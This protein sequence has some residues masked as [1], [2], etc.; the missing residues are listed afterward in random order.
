MAG[1][2]AMAQGAPDPFFD[3][4]SPELDANGDHVPDD[5][6]IRRREIWSE[7]LSESERQTIRNVLYE[8]DATQTR[9]WLGHCFRILEAQL[10]E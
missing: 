6:A 3:G 7:P 2:E 10:G 1:W 5:P 9:R 8:G 4:I